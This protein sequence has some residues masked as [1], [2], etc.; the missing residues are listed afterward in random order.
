MSMN[1]KI[2]GHCNAGEAE[3]LYII[4]S[5]AEWF[6]SHCNTSWSADYI[7]SNSYYTRKELDFISLYG[8]D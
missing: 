1:F 5:K 6:C 4:N 3:L 8:E 2:C 7:T